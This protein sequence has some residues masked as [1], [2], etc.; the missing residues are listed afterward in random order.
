MRLLL[1]FLVCAVAV[2]DAAFWTRVISQLSPRPD[3]SIVSSIAQNFNAFIVT[4]QLSNDRR[5]SNFLGQCAV[6]S[7]YFRTT[8]EYASGKKYNGRRDLGNIYPNDGP[9]F[10]GRGLIQLTGRSNYAKAAAIV[11]QDLVG[12]PELVATF[13][14]ALTV[15]GIYWQNRHVVGGGT[16]NDLAD[17]NDYIGVT[18]N[19]MASACWASSTASSTPN[20]RIRS[21]RE[22][23]RPRWRHR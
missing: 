15:S 7:A 5:I 11:H 21:C 12:H 2:R 10:K 13:P 16:L 4:F 18:R 3:P 22:I 23:A 9:R 8:T 19:V 14:L 20:S 1:A 17:Q 6:E